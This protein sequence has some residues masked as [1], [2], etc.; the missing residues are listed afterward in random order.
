MGV[1]RVLMGFVVSTLSW[2]LELLGFVGFVVF[3]FHGFV[4]FGF[5]A[6]M[7]WWVLWFHWLH[8]CCEF[9]VFRVFLAVS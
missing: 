5:H 6:L 2:V 3:R 9:P 8:G 1:G 7:L 4:V